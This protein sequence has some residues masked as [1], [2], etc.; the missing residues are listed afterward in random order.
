MKK[1]DAR[2]CNITRGFAA[3]WR[4]WLDAGSWPALAIHRKPNKRFSVISNA[5]AVAPL[6]VH[7]RI[8]SAT[9]TRSPSS[10]FFV[11]FII[12]GPAQ[13]LASFML[14][15]FPPSPFIPR[16]VHVSTSFPHGIG[17]RPT[18]FP[19]VDIYL[20]SFALATCVA[21]STAHGRT[22]SR[23]HAHCFLFLLFQAFAST[24]HQEIQRR[25]QEAV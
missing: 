4:S 16:N 8:I 20:I 15:R 5:S 22:A 12:R 3:R 6:L 19:P 18:C 21:S 14:Q 11:F 25:S 17:T 7:V 9:L 2:V 10:I 1:E 23:D 24:H 13:S